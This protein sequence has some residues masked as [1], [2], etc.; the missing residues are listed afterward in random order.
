MV[1][2]VQNQAKS[3][4][5]SR[6]SIL[7]R[8][9]GNGPPTRMKNPCLFSLSMILLVSFH[10]I[11]QDCLHRALRAELNLDQ[12][13]SCLYG[14]LPH[15]CLH[16]CVHLHVCVLYVSD[17]ACLCIYVCVCVNVIIWHIWQRAL[18]VEQH[19]RHCMGL[20]SRITLCM[21]LNKCH[22]RKASRS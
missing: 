11:F 21:L 19:G 14:C 16:S 7:G 13:I 22:Q 1:T 2:S 5:G 4:S 17:E 15:M 12:E 20:S 9:K 10:V 6:Q 8:E 18:W 3:L